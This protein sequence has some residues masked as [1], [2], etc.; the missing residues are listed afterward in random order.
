[1]KGAGRGGG[2]GGPWEVETPAHFAKRGQIW[3]GWPPR[4]LLGVP[5]PPQPHTVMEVTGGPSSHPVP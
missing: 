4:P 3:L 5:A 1:M 2:A